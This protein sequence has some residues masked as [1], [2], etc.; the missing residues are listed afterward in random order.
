VI[1]CLAGTE[2]GENFMYVPNSQ[3]RFPDPRASPDLHTGGMQPV[4]VDASVALYLDRIDDV[5]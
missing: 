2:Q 5:L 3:P 4:P 1:C